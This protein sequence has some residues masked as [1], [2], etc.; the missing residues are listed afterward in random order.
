MDSESSLIIQNVSGESNG[1]VGFGIYLYEYIANSNSSNDAGSAIQPPQ[2][3]VGENDA[4]DS[5]SIQWVGNSGA[6]AASTKAASDLPFPHT[7]FACSP[8]LLSSLYSPDL[9][10]PL[11][12]LNNLTHD[13]PI[14]MESVR[15]DQV[16]PSLMVHALSNT[17]IMGLSFAEDGGHARDL[18][19]LM[20]GEAAV[21]G[22]PDLLF[23]EYSGVS[24][25]AENLYTPRNLISSPM[26]I[27]IAF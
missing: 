23:L 20:S 8:S 18:H 6:V 4:P 9:D 12:I 3:S 25:W 11:S 19:N 2:N 7:N 1:L 10:I 26:E 16:S 27:G 22:L 21:C 14:M 15:L 5:T 17:P 13:S 24:I